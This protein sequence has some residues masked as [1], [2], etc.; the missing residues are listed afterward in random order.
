[1]AQHNRT[2]KTGE[3]LAIAYLEEKGY[4]ILE[5]NWHAGHKE[6][7]IIAL[8]KKFLVFIE[9]KTRSR[10]DYEEPWQAVNDVKIRRSVQA[11]NYYIRLKAID[12][13]PRFDIISI[14]MLPDKQVRIE[15]LEDAFT[16]LLS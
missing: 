8:D 11:A 3:D 13:E 9:V 10:D 12:L 15:H 1:M 4:H 2:G 16:A 7:D 6:L 5:R 14:L